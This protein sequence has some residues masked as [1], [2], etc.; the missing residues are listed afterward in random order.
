VISRSPFQGTAQILRY[1]VG[2]YVFSV[3]ALL[4]GVAVLIV[5]PLPFGLRWL[6]GAAECLG[7]WWLCASIVAS[8]WIYDSSELMRWEW[9]ARLVPEKPARWVNLHAGLDESSVALSQMW[10]APSAVFDF[11]DEGEMT[12]KSIHRARAS[13]A[14]TAESVSYRK[15][16]LED[17]V[18]D[19]VC[20]IFSAHELRSSSAREAFFSELSRVVTDR[21]LVV[22]HVRDFANF[23]A[24][25][26][27][28][29]HFFPDGEWRRLGKGAGFRLGASGRMTPFVRYY[30]WEKP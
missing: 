27:G 29:F 30:I 13:A 22:E 10:G 8:Y 21:L 7:A 11:F 20:V 2:F 18:A 25:G 6:G 3:I 9:L 1:N 5:L 28:F 17:G 26:P 19:L 24:F 15:L 16:P 23:I 4:V 12:E 14:G